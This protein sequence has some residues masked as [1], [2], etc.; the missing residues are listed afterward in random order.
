M[1]RLFHSISHLLSGLKAN[2]ADQEI[3]N[4]IHEHIND[5]GIDFYRAVI[6]QFGIRPGDQ[7]AAAFHKPAPG[8]GVTRQTWENCTGNQV[9]QPLGYFRPGS[10]DELRDIVERG[11]E[12]GCKVKA[13]GSG[14]SF[15]DITLTTD[16]MIDT[17][18][19]NH[20]LDLEAGLL[21]DSTE[22]NNLFKAECGIIIQDLNDT[23]DQKGLGLLNMG[24]YDGQTIAGVISTSTHGSGL[25]LGPLSSAVVSLV[26][27]T[28]D[29]K[30]IQIEPADGITDPARF[31]AAHPEIQLKQDDDWFHSVV[32]SMGCMGIIYAVTLQVRERYWLT[33]TRQLS[34]WD[35]VKQDLRDGSVLRD[36]RHYEVAVNPYPVN[37]QRSCLVTKRNKTAA[38]ESADPFKERNIFSDLVPRLPG[39][40]EAL[41]FLFDQYPQLTPSILDSAMKQLVDD[42]YVN[43]SYRVLNLGAANYIS[44]YSSEIA[45]PLDAGVQ[46][47]EK[48]FEIAEQNRAV[49][50]LYHTSPI[51]LRFV[52]QSEDYLSMQYGR[53]TCMIEIPMINGTIGGTEILKKYETALYQL[54]GRPHWGQINY[55]TAGRKLLLSMYPELQKWLAV[56]ATLNASA[57]FEN[58][59]TDRCGFASAD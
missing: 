16:F 48:I 43:V 49:G 32:V 45:F 36:N 28:A 31:I 11:R 19:L 8:A 5:M 57:M 39:A 42:G 47:A 37:G 46:A 29:N 30:L 54:S 1:S 20:V 2:P 3:L 55:L 9:A 14:H 23:L 21:K 10:L 33:E 13:I 38:R 35:Q 6:Q 59:F 17:H 51:S 26:L 25:S 27:L 41:L 18:S 53:D 7:G 34:T 56:Y 24:G 52:K 40:T 22:P 58:S 12:S 44:A 50:N 15:S 4:Q